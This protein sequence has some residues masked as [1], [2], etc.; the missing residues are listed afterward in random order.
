MRRRMIYLMVCIHNVDTI[1]PQNL[2]I[3]FCRRHIIY[4]Q[5]S[6]QQGW[7]DQDRGQLLNYRI[8]IE[9]VKYIKCKNIFRKCREKLIISCFS[10]L[11]QSVCKF[12]SVQV[13]QLS[14]SATT[15]TL[16]LGNLAIFNRKSYFVK[17]QIQSRDSQL[18][19]FYQKLPRL[20]I[21]R[22]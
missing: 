12:Q 17:L 19:C 20:K 9:D 5:I 1:G 15:I 6:R 11:R 7:E 16:F 14:S 10:L 13:T 18:I 4:K 21:N 8:Y 22:L 2:Y 3:A